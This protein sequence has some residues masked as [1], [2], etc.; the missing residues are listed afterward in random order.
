MSE[1][2]IPSVERSTRQPFIKETPKRF[3]GISLS[4]GKSDKACLAVIEYF[5]KY[6][7][8]FLVKLVEKIKNDEEISADLKIHDLVSSYG[9][10]VNFLCLD[11]PLQLPKCLRCDLPCPG[12]ETCEEPEILWMWSYTKKK[13]A[14]KKPKKLFTPYTQRCVEMYLSSE[15][16]EPFILQHGLGSNV[17]PLT[18]RAHFIQR[19]FEIPTLEVV[20]KLSIWRIGHGLKV[21]KR[22]LRFHKHS[23][24][25]DDSRR[26]ILNALIDHD[27][28][29]VYQQDISLMV[30]NNHAF[31]AFICALTGFLE[32]TKQTEPRPAHFPKNESWVAIPKKELRWS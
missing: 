27:V 32:Y 13:N 9:E 11:V 2:R 17:A 31:E 3:I 8:I 19:R 10:N 5:E 6:N 24:A 21:M 4:G 30:E 15:L 7:K 28:A 1:R 29:F 26:A 25:G 22:H 14:K 12:Y 16:E 20:P 23:V 18:A